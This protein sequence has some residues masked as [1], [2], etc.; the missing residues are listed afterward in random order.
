MGYKAINNSVDLMAKG[1]RT[2]I[3]DAYDFINNAEYG[4]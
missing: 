4:K 1:S 3:V 2:L